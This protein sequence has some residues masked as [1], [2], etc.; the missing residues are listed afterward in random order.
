[1]LIR[2]SLVREMI[3]LPLFS[4]DMYQIPGPSTLKT[5]VYMEI[6]I[7]NREEIIHNL[8]TYIDHLFTMLYTTGSLKKIEAD[9]YFRECLEDIFEYSLHFIFEEDIDTLFQEIN[10]YDLPLDSVSPP[11]P[12]TMDDYD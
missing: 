12:E 6:N 4:G 2:L 1:M 5:I 11:V 10:F 9:Q 3:E 7:N 8:K